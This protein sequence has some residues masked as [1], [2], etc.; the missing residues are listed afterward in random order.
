MSTR[1]TGK[2]V[3][4]E[5]PGFSLVEVVVALI[6]LTVAIF[7]SFETISYALSIT[8]EVRMRMTSY[9]QLEHIGLLSAATKEV[10]KSDD[11]LHSSALHSVPID[12]G[13]DEK[14]AEIT[15]LVY[16]HDPEAVRVRFQKMKSPVFIVF[17]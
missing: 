9:S 13:G 15:R 5:R 6:A 7:A 2:K 10:V 14:S 1:R 4:A 17:F 8:T 3:S 12:I 16:K 11:I